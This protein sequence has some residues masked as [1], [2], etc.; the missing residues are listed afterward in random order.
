[1]S[2]RKLAAIAL[3]IGS[4]AGFVGNAQS[5][6]LIHDYQLNGSLADSLGGPSLVAAGGVLSANG[7]AFGANQGLSL[8]N[9]L[10][11]NGNYSIELQFSFSDVSGYRKVLDFK[12]RADDK[13][14][15][16]LTSNLNFYPFA[17]P[18]GDPFTADVLADVILT[19]NVDTNQTNGYVNGAQFFSFTD[20]GGDAVFNAAN[21]II[22]FFKDDF[23]TQGGEASAGCVRRIRVFDSALDITEVTDAQA[24][25]A[26]SCGTNDVPEPGSLALLGLGLAALATRKSFTKSA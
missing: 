16:V 13:G 18:S 2:I 22:Q 3:L 8:S 20:G 1:M 26:G 12:D 25:L 4:A 15:Y 6:A 9:G 5:A 14:F 19:R 21:G 10:G 11:D 17:F 24:P 23:V 7:Y